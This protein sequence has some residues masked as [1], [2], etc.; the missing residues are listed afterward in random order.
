MD[1]NN[2]PLFSNIKGDFFGGLTAGIV[3]LPLA[4]AFGLSSGLGPDAGLYGAIFIAFFAAAFG[5]TNTQ[6]SGPTAPMTAVSMVI[7]ASIVQQSNGD[8]EQAIPAILTVFLLAGVILIGLGLLGIGTYIRYIPYPVVSGFMTAIGVIIII[9]QLLPM[10]GYYASEDQALI[11]RFKPQA[12]EVLLDKI[13]K[14]EAGE[15]I[16][17]LEVFEE[18]IRRAKQVGQDD[19]ALEAKTLASNHASGVVG[20]IRSLGRAITNINLIEFLLCMI[21]IF[22]IYGFKRIT[23]SIPS[24]LVALVVVTLGAVLLQN[25]GVLNYRP[26]PEIPTGF[27]KPRL[28]II[29]GF[30]FGLIAPYILTAFSLALL[31]A[32]DSLLTSIVADNLTKT[33]HKPNKELIGQGIGNGIAAIFGGIPGAG[34]TIRTVVNIQAGGKTRLSG[35]IAGVLLLMILLVLGPIASMIPAAVLAGILITVGIGV[36]DYKGLK[37]LPLMPK[38]EVV[39]LLVVLVLSVFWNLVY[40]VGIGLVIAALIFM[41]KMADITSQ[42]SELRHL[43]E[44]TEDKVYWQ[45]EGKLSDEF[46]EKVFIKHLNGPLFFGFTSDFQDMVAKIPSE[47]T[48]VILRMGRVP[49]IDQ[50]GLFA[51]EDAIIDMEG[52]GIEVL[53]TGLKDQPRFLMEQIRIIPDLIQDEHVYE[54]FAEGVKWIESNVVKD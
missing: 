40:A 17:V 13:L 19:I 8:L 37:A 29:T 28:E 22:I 34:A 16:L 26:I 41:K 50:S 35:M 45:D 46:K 53:L 23:K 12:E 5:G 43:K 9:T 30:N 33:K 3:A 4:L 32:I 14:D 44:H 38:T 27:P 31:G 24:T 42:E 36:M 20:A 52:K 48:H 10:F 39:V 49:Y 15:G 2:P 54:T 21:T 11:D 51:L 18:T 47:A 25:A 7:I 6:I 1:K